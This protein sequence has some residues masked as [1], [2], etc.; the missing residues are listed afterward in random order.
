M[1]VDGVLALLGIRLRAP[2]DRRAG[3]NRCLRLEPQ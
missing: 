3:L 1:G 2:L